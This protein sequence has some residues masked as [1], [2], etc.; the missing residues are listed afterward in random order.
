M[1]GRPIKKR[2]CASPVSFRALPENEI[3]PATR[4]DIYFGPLEGIRT[5]DLQNRNLLRYP[6][7]PQAEILYDRQGVLHVGCLINFA[8]HLALFAFILISRCIR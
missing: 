5:P 8:K 1:A 3:P 6:A 2:T 4:V 7:A